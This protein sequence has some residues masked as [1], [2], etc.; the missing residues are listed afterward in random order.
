MGNRSYR[1]EF[2]TSPQFFI[3]NDGVTYAGAVTDTAPLAADLE[4]IESG[5]AKKYMPFTDI[6][7]VNNSSVALFFYPN[8]DTDRKIVIPAGV[9]KTLDKNDMPALSSFQIFTKSGTAA[10]DEIEVTVWK[11]GVV[12]DDMAKIQHKKMFQKGGFLF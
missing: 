2:E 11:R 6:E 7:I 10:V 12:Q 3:S 5:K 9:I 1:R 8:Q 4:T